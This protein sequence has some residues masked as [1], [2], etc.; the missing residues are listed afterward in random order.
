MPAPPVD[1]D[2]VDFASDL[3]RRAGALSLQWF[4]SSS[5]HIATKTDGSPVT[6]AD[7]AVERLLRD[8]IAAAF[9]DDAV[10]GEEEADR[11][12]SSGRTWIV[13]PIDGT[14]AFSR[15][16]PLYAN[17]L[18]YEDEHGPAVGVINIPALGETVSAGRGLGCHHN[19]V[20]C[21]VSPTATLEASYATTSGLDVWPEAMLRRMLG[22]PVRLRT[23]GDGYGYLLVATGRVEAMIDP[24]VAPYDI[25]P[26]RTIL[27]EAGGRFSDLRGIDRADG[28]S[29]IA[30]NAVLHDAFLALLG[31]G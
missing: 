5:L 1:R 2:L 30:T 12:G 31:A 14:K 22:S 4:G 21:Q 19:G 17:L 24:V 27:P 23:W 9:P 20:R 3:A 8:E 13:D 26:M 25:A 28:G 11:P 18:A 10:L 6:E 7:L 29:G 15:G 16:V